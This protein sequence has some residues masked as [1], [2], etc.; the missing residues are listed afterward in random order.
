M[1]YE[2]KNGRWIVITTSM[3]RVNV[4]ND[5]THLAWACGGELRLAV[6]RDGDRLW[7]S[8]NSY[9][10]NDAVLGAASVFPVDFEGR[11]PARFEVHG[12]DIEV[13]LSGG[14]R[15]LAGLAKKTGASKIALHAGLSDNMFFTPSD[16]GWTAS[17]ALDVSLLPREFL[18]QSHG[19]NSLTVKIEW[20]WKAEC[21][22]FFTIDGQ[23]LEF[24][25]HRACRNRDWQV[26]LTF[27]SEIPAGVTLGSQMTIEPIS[28]ATNGRWLGLPK[29]DNGRVSLRQLV[30]LQKEGL[31]FHGTGY[32]AMVTVSFRITCGEIYHAVCGN[33][34]RVEP[35]KVDGNHAWGFGPPHPCY[36]GATVQRLSVKILQKG[37][38][39]AFNNNALAAGRLP[40]PFKCDE[41][42]LLLPNF[43]EDRTVAGVFALACAI[44]AGRW[45]AADVLELGDQFVCWRG[46]VD[47]ASVQTVKVDTK[48]RYLLKLTN[49]FTLEGEKWIAAP[50]GG[51]AM[52]RDGR[53][54][55]ALDCPETSRVVLRDGKWM[56][57]GRW[58]KLDL[59]NGTGSLMAA[60]VVHGAA[61]VTLVTCQNPLGASGPILEI[62]PER[63][64]PI[65]RGWLSDSEGYV[66]LGESKLAL[67]E[68]AKKVFKLRPEQDP[69]SIPIPNGVRA[70][71]RTARI[72]PDQ[73]EGICNG[74]RWSRDE[75]GQIE[76]WEPPNTGIYVLRTN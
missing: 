73:F 41:M 27:D 64:A 16:R 60:A 2:R 67:T 11:E 44:P 61:A 74:I 10:L 47:I 68:T 29:S 43:P 40:A 36:P 30:D 14:D 75:N 12:S 54:W 7:F 25:V 69:S 62:G 32:T 56:V 63:S 6:L 59:N 48:S 1:Q 39:A 42:L 28:S 76:A 65:L 72:S 45:E 58:I 21:S 19:S 24:D 33:N 8:K 66:R 38:A 49:G 46:L 18:I 23:N 51:I 34:L 52:A 9:V 50:F 31:S 5:S 26:G 37:V 55:G 71:F 22:S 35:T 13:L 70:A 20:L 3:R 15:A 53:W 17:T 57:H 4:P